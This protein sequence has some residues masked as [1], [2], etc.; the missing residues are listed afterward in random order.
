MSKDAT[1][2]ADPAPPSTGPIGRSSGTERVKGGSEPRRERSPLE[3][4]AQRLGQIAAR[5]ALRRS[6]IAPPP[7]LLF[8][9]ALA[10]AVVMAILHVHLSMALLPR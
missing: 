5:E 10:Y 2:P 8:A 4:I 1:E 9:L 7:E 6:C 3:G